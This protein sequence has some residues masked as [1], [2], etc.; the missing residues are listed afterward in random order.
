MK[1]TLVVAAT[2]TMEQNKKAVNRKCLGEKSS[3]WF[4]SWWGW[5]HGSQ[6]GLRQY[7]QKKHSK[8]ALNPFHFFPSPSVSF[9]IVVFF[10]TPPPFPCD[11]YFQIVSKHWTWILNKADKKRAQLNSLIT[12]TFELLFGAARCVRARAWYYAGFIIIIIIIITMTMMMMWF[13]GSIGRS[14]KK[15][16]RRDF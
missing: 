6:A 12:Y 16:R 13:F 9:F 7:G 5:W 4:I 1:S 3:N 11:F 14:G 2:L 15:K 8:S 10:S